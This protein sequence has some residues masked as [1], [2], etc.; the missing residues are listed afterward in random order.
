MYDSASTRAANDRLWQAI[1]QDF[2]RGP[3]RLDRTADPHVTWTSP[4]LLLSQTC[5][6]PFRTDLY[7]RVALIGTPDYGIRGCAPGYY[8]SCIVVRRDDPRNHLGEFEG[9][10]LARNDIRSQSGWA[11][12]EQELIDRSLG[13]SFSEA[14][15]DTGSHRCAAQAVAEARADLASLDAVTWTL[16]KRETS[17]AR[18]LRVLTT[19]RP[20]PGL[21]FIT[22][23]AENPRLLFAA[24]TRAIETLSARDRARLLLRGLVTIP[25]DAYLAIPVPKA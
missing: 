19:T 22:S 2:G 16:L 17:L 4:D 23:R 21:P 11:A 6:L 25:A 10:R 18:H 7:D 8:K 9:A 24:I 1:R 13:F 15:I 3:D 5:G 20:T 12:I 14:V